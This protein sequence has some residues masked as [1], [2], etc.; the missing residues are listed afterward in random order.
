M[1][2]AR[3]IMQIG[4]SAGSLSSLFEAIAKQP[5]KINAGASPF[6]GASV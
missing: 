4:Q 3:L 6:L 2:L 1:D 5:L